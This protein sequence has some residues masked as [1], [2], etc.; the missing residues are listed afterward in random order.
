MRTY[1]KIGIVLFLVL[2]VSYL[3]YN[4]YANIQHKKEVANRIKSIPDFKFKV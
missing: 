3:G 2:V 1:I 4:L